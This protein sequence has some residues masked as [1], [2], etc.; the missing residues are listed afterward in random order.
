R[1]VGSLLAARRDERARARR[2]DAREVVLRG[3]R[4]PRSARAPAR[5]RGRSLSVN[6]EFLHAL[7]VAHPIVQAP[8]GGANATPPVLVGGV[9]TGGGRGLVGGAYS[10]PE[11]ITRETR[12]IRALTARPFGINLFVPVETPRPETFDN[13]IAQ[14]SAYHT[15]LGLPA[16]SMPALPPYS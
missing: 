13:A 11:Q 3:T 7:G 16:P 6:N 5:R 10:P 12:A 1:G 15:E 14:I 8:M 2:E 9:G 4:V